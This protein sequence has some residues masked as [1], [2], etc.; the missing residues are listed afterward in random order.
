MRFNIVKIITFLFIVL[1]AVTTFSFNSEAETVSSTVL[2]PTADAYVNANAKTRN[3]GTTTSLTTIKSPE[4]I[5][6]LKFDLSSLSNK[7][8]SKAQLTLKVTNTSTNTQQ[9]RQVTNTSWNETTLKYNNKPQIQST[10]LATFVPNT[11]GNVTIDL[12]SFIASNAGKTVSLAIISNGNN[13][14]V[15]NSREANTGKPALTVTLN[16]ATPSP[17]QITTVAPTISTVTPTVLPTLVPTA[18]AVPTTVPTITPTPT[19]TT[20]ASFTVFDEALDTNWEDWSWNS[21]NNFENTQSPFAGTLHLD[22]KS[23]AQWSGIYLHTNAG[24]N[25]TG[26]SALTFAIKAT[27]QNSQIGLQLYDTQDNGI[28]QFIDISAYGGNPVVGNYKTYTIPL[29]DLQGVNK[30][31]NGFHIQDISG[32]NSNEFFLDA[33]KFIGNAQPTPTGTPVPTPTASPTATPTIVPTSTPTP[34]ATATPSAIPTATPTNAPTPT[35][36]PTPTLTNTPTP[37]AT[38]TATPTIVPTSTPAPTGTPAPTPTSTVTSNVPNN[39]VEEATN[40]IP[41]SWHTN[42]WGVNSPTFTYL[43]TGHTGS[44]SVKTEI[45]SYTSGDAKW[46]YDAQSVTPNKEYT[47]TD[48]YQSNTESRV[49]V[50]IKKTD[51]SFS[52]VDLA[53]APVAA[54]WTKY[55]ATFT[56]PADAQSMIVLHVVSAVGFLIVDDYQLLDSASQSGFDR[57]IVTITWDDGVESQY[58]GAFPIHQKYNLPGTFYLISGLLNN[59]SFYMTTSQALEL[60]AA[61]NELGAHTMTHP[62]LTTL[63]PEEVQTELGQ[64]QTDLQN[65]FGISFIDFVSPYGEYDDAVMAVIQQYYRSHRTVEHGYNT[66]DNFDIYHLKIQ[67]VATTTT[68]AE[69]AAWVQTAKEDKT[70]LILMYHQVDNPTDPLS[71]SSA[72]LDTEFQMLKNSGVPVLTTDQALGEILPQLGN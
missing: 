58:T 19:S 50:E 5:S 32:S 2:N 53:N 42:T 52:Y 61:G 46:Y 6:Y 24:F 33:I 36:T 59:D 14:A 41:N 48:Y 25:T 63:T 69:V 57:G 40:D 55:Q 34:T 64:S 72:D 70:W 23:L 12:T 13:N 7:E 43:N 11:T 51:G 44:H 39:S 45:T 31:I 49:V 10:T 29:A 27:T 4:N 3:Y 17:S 54:D 35:S 62:H 60:L 22:W 21:Q 65:M 56:T 30:T 67:E 28:G 38:P 16:S 26:Y 18:T 9:I 47:F 1:F 66:K 15:I 20:A 37:T 71:V 8:I 68:P